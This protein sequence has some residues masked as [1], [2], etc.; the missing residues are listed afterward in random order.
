MTTPETWTEPEIRRALSNITR[1]TAE[2]LVSWHVCVTGRSPL[3]SR[4][5]LPREIEALHRRA[6][7]LK[8]VLNAGS[9][10]GQN[11]SAGITPPP[12]ITSR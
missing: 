2:E 11:P 7:V 9:S 5:S 12:A 10:P 1:L 3:Y 8:I 4:S 6:R